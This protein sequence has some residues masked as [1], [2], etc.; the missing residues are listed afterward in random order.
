ML[1]GTWR[2]DN[3]II[4]AIPIINRLPLSVLLC[5]FT[6]SAWGQDATVEPSRPLDLT[7]PSGALTRTWGSP[8]DADAAR[9]PGLGEHPSRPGAAGGPGSVGRGGGRRGDLP[10]GTGYEARHGQAGAG[11]GMGRGR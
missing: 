5:V 8:I 7:V 2:I 4:E 11:R 6:A 9:L 3:V 10:Y 1:Q